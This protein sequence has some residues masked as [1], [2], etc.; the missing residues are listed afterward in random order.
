MSWDLFSTWGYVSIGLWLAVPLLWAVHAVRRPRRWLCH[1]AVI[2]ALVGLVCAK[3]NSE[4]HVN[5]IQID[6]SEE[7]AAAQAR[8]EAARRAAEEARGGEVAQVRFAE[9]DATDYLDEGGMDDADRKYMATFDDAAPQASQ[10][11]G[12]AA[13]PDWKKEKKT[14]S[15]TP[16]EDDSLEAMLDTT[17]A[18]AGGVDTGLIEGSAAEPILMPEKQMM[19]ANR[20]DGFNL[21][22]IR[23]LI[24]VAAGVVV[25]DYLKRLNS[26]PDAYF[27]LPLPS[28]WTNSLT[29]VPPVRTWPKPQRRTMPKELEWLVRKGETFLYLCDERAAAAVPEQLARCPRGK[30]QVDIIHVT[31]DNPVASEFIFETL[32]YGRSSFVVD[33][34]AAADTLLARMIDLLELRKANRAHVRQ[35][36]HIVWD[37]Q[38]PPSAETVDAFERL[39]QATGF[40]L[41]TRAELGIVDS[42]R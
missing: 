2:L 35:T 24:L 21:K 8:Q 6:R 37:L 34:E 12:Q 40:T 13:T 1:Y 3:I 28:R 41:V 39:G 32:W 20:L 27:P 23:W 10:A 18:D 19:L 25:L 42:R 30:H 11:G 26:Y 5:R 36:V 31:A 22:L 33:S 14:R 15:E 16:N 29:P 4:T 9:D 38:A 17:V 7:L